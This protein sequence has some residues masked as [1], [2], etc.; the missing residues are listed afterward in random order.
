MDFE[1]NSSDI[2]SPEYQKGFNEGYL[3]ATHEPEISIG[4]SVA[5]GVS[6]RLAG[7]KAGINE[8][9]LEK[10]KDKLPMPEWL[11]PQVQTDKE[12]GIDKDKEN[13]KEIDLDKD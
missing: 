7:M 10:E 12:K 9:N 3:L 8:A 1:E 11:S 2:M 6:E 13:N 4:I 5:E